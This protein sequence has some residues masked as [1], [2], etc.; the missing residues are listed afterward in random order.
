VLVTLRVTS[1]LTRSVRSTLQG[2]EP[3][4][5]PRKILF[6]GGSGLLGSELRGLL[7]EPARPSLKIV[8]DRNN[9][10]YLA[11]AGILAKDRAGG[12]LVDWRGSIDH[13]SSRAGVV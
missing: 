10:F 7:P 13:F 12:R 1:A 8:D 4:V 9:K 2:K 6:T 11:E 5:E 3:M